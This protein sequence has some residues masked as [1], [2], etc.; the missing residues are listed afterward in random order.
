MTYQ[1]LESQN[2]ENSKYRKITQDR[3]V[4][5]NES[6]KDRKII[7]KYDSKRLVQFELEQG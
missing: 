1:K 2:D 7:T 4:Q 5:K 3:K 6:K